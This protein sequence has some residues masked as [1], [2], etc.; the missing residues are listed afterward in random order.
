MKHRIA[1]MFAAPL[2]V[3]IG[4]DGGLGGDES[5][6]G[7]REAG[8]REGWTDKQGAIAIVAR[9]KA[10]ETALATWDPT[11]ILN[12]LGWLSG[13]TGGIVFG[14]ATPA[15][16]ALTSPGPNNASAD[17]GSASCGA[18]GCFFVRYL[19]LDVGARSEIWNG[20]ISITT[21]TPD[22]RSVT[23][24]VTYD[25]LESLVG[26]THLTA[27]WTLTASRLDGSIRDVSELPSH[28]ENVVEFHG[29]TLSDGEPTG[30]SLY[31]KWVSAVYGAF[32]A[33]VLFP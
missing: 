33:T 20:A 7:A 25:G 8:V 11:T 29:V 4:C 10:V 31:A 2:V 26:P 19:H 23:L 15:A 16:S 32:E 3:L 6:G 9:T 28:D 1:V 21:N 14:S 18:G 27:A 22:A 5:D 13:N 30:G 12:Q 24:D 17:R